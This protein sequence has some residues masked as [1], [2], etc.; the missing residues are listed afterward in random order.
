MT[1]FQTRYVDFVN[2]LQGT[3][4][5][6]RY[7]NGNTLPLTQLPNGMVSW[8]LQTSYER[9][10]WF[11]HPNDV[12]IE[13]IRLTH[14]PSPWI[15]DYGQLLF[16][17]Q[18][19][20]RTLDRSAWH[21][22]YTQ[23]SLKPYCL[24]LLLRRDNIHY[25]MVPTDRGGV[26]RIEFNNKKSRM[27]IQSFG[28]YG[29]ET[30]FEIDYIHDV[31]IGYTKVAH[32]NVPDN[33]AQYFYIKFNKPILKN[34]VLFGNQ[35][36]VNIYENCTVG[37][38]LGAAIELDL[39]DGLEMYMYV[40]TS[41]ISIE[42]AQLNYEREQ[43]GIEFEALKNRAASV[44]ETELSKIEIETKKDC[45]KITF[46]SSLYR[47]L[48]FPRKIYEYDVDNNRVHFGMFSGKIE[49]GYMYTDIGF[50]DTFR[51]L[52]PL[53]ALIRRELYGKMV[54]G[55][56]NVYKESGWLPKWISPCELGIM[57][58]TLI[59]G[60]LADAGIKGIPFD[61]E[62]A[63][64]GMIKHATTEPM[65]S[66]YGRQGISDY[67]VLGYVPNEK[68]ESVNQ[69]LDHAYG[70]FCIAQIA[71]L[72]KQTEVAEKYM[73]RGQ[74]Y[75][76][77]YDKSTGFMRSK[78][79]AGVFR[80]PFNS[81]SWGGDYCEGSAW[82][83]SWFIAHDLENYLRHVGSRNQLEQKLDTLFQSAREFDVGAYGQEIHEMTEMANAPF[84]Q[85]AISNQPSFHIPYLYA[86]IGKP[87]KT[88]FWV[89]EIIE[90]GFGPL[91]D[92]FPG[93]ED[94]GSMSA[95]YVLSTLGLYPLVPGTEDYIVA[96]CHWDEIKI[97]LQN[98]R[99]F[100]IINQIGS[101]FEQQ[102]HITLN[103]LTVSNNVISYKAIL[104][105]GCLEINDH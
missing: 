88:A 86:A 17:P 82:Q 66:Q 43:K 95:W 85:C 102:K 8:T 2:I 96:Y 105:G 94:N 49:Q 16:M 53:M 92:G 76:N 41:F 58:G 27:L 91:A 59:D 87:T 97:H 3:D 47:T 20:E 13:G 68:K 39:S 98:K 77:L 56:L 25:Q 79:A 11:F 78:N 74:N 37:V 104:D 65:K 100:K 38:E 73:K 33:Y 29:K 44:W 72:L 84:G 83:N 18:S 75:I 23:R 40:A 14:Q 35:G 26:H 57:P 12:A 15:G 30:K 99:C 22:S 93:D 67:Q 19:G 54:Q 69:T 51:T 7:S 48:L 89:K 81:Y 52:F 101:S 31:V 36:N 103:G 4:S 34:S 9:G 60:V 32:P 61:L 55:F 1:S 50:W 45:D 6:E 5:C 64:E 80:T 62:L 71:T 21:S 63:L 42:Q 90:K 10:N 70:D 28:T 24:S 46:Y